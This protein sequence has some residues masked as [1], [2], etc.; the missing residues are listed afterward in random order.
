MSNITRL[1]VPS[2]PALGHCP[3][4]LRCS[5]V[6]NLGGMDW[7]YCKAHG[8]KWRIGYGIL[9]CWPEEIEDDWAMNAQFLTWFADAVYW[10]PPDPDEC[11]PANGHGAA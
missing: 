1:V 4:C 7:G 5:G 6:L 2:D 8:V 11:P 9:K 3:T 10:L